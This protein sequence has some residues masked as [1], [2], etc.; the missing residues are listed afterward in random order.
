[1][2]HMFDGRPIKQGVKI[3]LNVPDSHFAPWTV[4]EG[5]TQG[6]VQTP[7]PS[8]QKNVWIRSEGA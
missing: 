1:M 8:L 4:N 5:S 7:L 2:F 3:P 6:L